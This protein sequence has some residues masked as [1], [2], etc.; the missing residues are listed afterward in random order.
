MP[1]THAGAEDA[2]GELTRLF[3]TMLDK[4]VERTSKI[5][6]A[7]PSEP[8]TNMSA[9]INEKAFK[10]INSYIEKGKSEGGRVLIGGFSRT[11][12]PG[13]RVGVIGPNGAGKT[14][15]LE[16]IAGR[17]APDAGSLEVG[18]TVRLGY[19][20]QES[21]ALDEQERILFRRQAAAPPWSHAS[22]NSQRRRR[23]S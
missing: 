22:R 4:I 1:V 19:Y 14:T 18:Q 12:S 15:L 5:K 11:L 2:I 9:V 13:E 20:D 3:N 17:V 16:I 6:M 23:S 21:R 7:D 10:S 8:A